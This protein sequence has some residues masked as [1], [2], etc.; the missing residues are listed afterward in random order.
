MVAIRNMMN[1]P[2]FKFTYVPKPKD[3]VEVQTTL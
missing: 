1:D 2:N 3:K